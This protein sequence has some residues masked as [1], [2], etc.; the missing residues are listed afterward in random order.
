VVGWHPHRPGGGGALT[1]AA[2]ATPAGSWC[3]EFHAAGLDTDFLLYPKGTWTG[4]GLLETTFDNTFWLAF[5][6][7]RSTTDAPNYTFD[8]AILRLLD[9]AGG[10]GFDPYVALPR[11]MWGIGVTGGNGDRYHTPTDSLPGDGSWHKV[12][13]HVEL[14]RN[15]VHSPGN[16]VVRIWIDDVLQLENTSAS[17]CHPIGTLLHGPYEGTYGGVEIGNGGG[18]GY[19]WFRIDDVNT[20]PPLLMAARARCWEV[21]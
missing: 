6:E 18:S 16:G 19:I 9:G 15:G 2:G 12:R 1:N 11:G 20:C 7:A 14:D 3:C 21:C 8:K 10:S 5:S 13:V 4:T 17:L